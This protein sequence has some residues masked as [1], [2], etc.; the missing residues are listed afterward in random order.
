MNSPKKKELNRALTCLYL[1][2]LDES[3]IKDISRIAREAVE[4]AEGQSTDVTKRILKILHD[5]FKC[6]YQGFAGTFE[7]WLEIRGL[8]FK[9]DKFEPVNEIKRTYS[10][11]VGEVQVNVGK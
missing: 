6:Y 8:Q 10:T 5:Q 7:E 2:P 3:I 9:E 1:T 11:R 4:E